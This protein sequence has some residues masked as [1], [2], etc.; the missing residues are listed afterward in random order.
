MKPVLPEKVQFYRLLV[1]SAARILLTL[2]KS[3]ITSVNWVGGSYGITNWAIMKT[4]LK[5]ILL[6]IAK[7]EGGSQGIT[8]WV[9]LTVH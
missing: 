7:R 4:I 6:Q 5:S 2:L 3:I 8:K 9:I 1:T